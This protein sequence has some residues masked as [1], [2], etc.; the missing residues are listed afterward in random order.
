KDPGVT[1]VLCGN[2]DL[3]FGVLRAMHEA[4][5]AVPDD[6][7]VVGFDDT[8]LAEFGTPSLTTVR[9]DFAE[10]GRACFALLQDYVRDPTS[11]RTGPA[12][13]LV[14]RESSGPP[15]RSADGPLL[16]ALAVAR[17]QFDGGAV[18]GAGPGDVETQS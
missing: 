16:V 13:V 15:G 8:P 11:V 14:R 7:S 5:R 17:P 18:G 2:D 10:L 6:V 1:A 12:P 4:G 3:A 9:L